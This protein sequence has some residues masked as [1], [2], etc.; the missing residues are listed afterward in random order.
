[1]PPVTLDFGTLSQAL[2]SS[3]AEP[4]HYI[5]D[6]DFTRAFNLRRRS[7]GGLDDH[8]FL[9]PVSM[10]TPSRRTAQPHE[11]AKCFQNVVFSSVVDELMALAT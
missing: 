11:C 4:E 9:V 3:K 2:F 10:A 6:P 8:H 1:V 7:P 5:M